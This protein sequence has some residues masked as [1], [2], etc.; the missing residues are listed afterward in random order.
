MSYDIIGD[1]HG[2]ATA[3]KRLL[4]K[5]GYEKRDGEWTCPGRQALFVGDFVDCGPEQIEAVNI[6][7]AMVD[8]GSAQAVM[9]NHDFNAIAWFVE[10][11]DNAGEYLRP[12]SS[13]RYGDKNY[14]QHKHFLDAIGSNHALH[15]EIIDWFLSLPLWL[16]LPEVRVVHACWHNRFIRFLGDRLVDGNRLDE[17][18]LVE[19]SREPSDEIEKDNAKPSM[20]KAVEAVLKG[21]EVPL[22]EGVAFKDKDDIE[23]T[24]VRVRWWD[25]DAR[26]YQSAALPGAGL[27]PSVLPAVDIPSHVQL[28][29]VG[30][31]PTFF[32]HY[33]FTGRPTVLS[34]RVACVDYSIAKGGK[35]AAY[36][37]DGESKLQSSRLVWVE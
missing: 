25:R 19:A 13:P 10:D 35:L 34:N 7:R 28:E 27:D 22:P 30:E 14:R 23:R 16:E 9:G 26:T 17:R 6:V 29:R 4:R 12:H 31:K 11:P 2:H 20:F 32:G 1:I 3:L 21:L 37:W 5:L 18:L 24:R 36:R 8:H 33:W 15:R